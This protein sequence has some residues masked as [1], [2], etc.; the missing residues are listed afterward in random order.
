ME[1]QY[2]IARFSN[3]TLKKWTIDLSKGESIENAIKGYMHR[4]NAGE[5]KSD[6]IKFY[7]KKKIT[8]EEYDA[9]GVEWYEESR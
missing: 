4:Q 7:E 8:K 2:W 6:R 1:K 9:L 5:A 3:Y